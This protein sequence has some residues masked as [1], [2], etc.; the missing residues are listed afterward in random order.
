MS[1]YQWILLAAIVLVVLMGAFWVAKPGKMHVVHSVWADLI[2]R[3]VIAALVV[4]VGVLGWQWMQCKMVHD[5]PPPDPAGGAVATQEACTHCEQSM[6]Q[7]TTEGGVQPESP[8]PVKVE[9]IQSLAYAVM[10]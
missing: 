5:E 6:P 9:K 8:A 3:M 10:D 1:I 2:Q 4:A 7:V